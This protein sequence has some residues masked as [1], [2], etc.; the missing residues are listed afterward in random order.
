MKATCFAVLAIGVLTVADQLGL[1]VRSMVAG[2]GVAGLALSFAAQ[3]TVANFISGSTLAIDQP[4]NVGD[5]VAISDLD[6]TVTEVRR[7]MR[8]VCA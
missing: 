3:D 7:C 2:L 5:W 8:R 1:S 4:F 6:A